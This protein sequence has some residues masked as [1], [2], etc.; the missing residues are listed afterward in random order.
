MCRRGEAQDGT[1][2]E[3]GTTALLFEELLG[4]GPIGVEDRVDIKPECV[5]PTAVRQFMERAV[6][7]FSSTAAR[8]VIKAI[9]PFEI[10]KGDLNSGRCGFG[11]RGVSG[12]DES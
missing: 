11:V 7:F 4:R 1:E 6:A 2:V 5:I 9:E 3:H 12:H 8:D 10:A